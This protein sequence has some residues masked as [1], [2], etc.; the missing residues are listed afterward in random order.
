[1]LA[2]TIIKDLE[3]QYGGKAR[4]VAEHL[5]N[6][7]KIYALGIGYSTLVVDDTGKVL[8]RLRWL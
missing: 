4:G 3:Q 8:S 7:E 2:T 1:M 5:V 6:G